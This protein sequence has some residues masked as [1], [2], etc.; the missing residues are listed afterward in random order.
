MEVM[1]VTD[2]DK[3]LPDQYYEHIEPTA[4]HLQGIDD[5]KFHPEEPTSPNLLWARN[6]DQCC[7]EL[8]NN[9]SRPMGGT[10]WMNTAY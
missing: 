9:A 4:E 5:N 8:P 7:Q 3:D 1:N 2:F 6:V 10:S